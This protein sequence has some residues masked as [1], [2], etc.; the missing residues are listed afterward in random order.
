MLLVWVGLGVFRVLRWGLSD[1]ERV[2]VGGGFWGLMIGRVRV[3]R[4]AR[5]R[6]RDTLV[7]KALVTEEGGR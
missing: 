7:D 3:G 1:W 4:W 5:P 2:E 6:R